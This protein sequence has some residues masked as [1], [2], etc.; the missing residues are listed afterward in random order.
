MRA[1]RN[2]NACIAGVDD[3]VDVMKNVGFEGC[4]DETTGWNDCSCGCYGLLAS[5]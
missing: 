4:C 5:D 1:L 2:S 3:V